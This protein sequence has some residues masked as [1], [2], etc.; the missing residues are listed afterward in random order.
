M[1]VDVYGL[2]DCTYCKLIRHALKKADLSWQEHSID[3]QEFHKLYPDQE[4]H[5]VTIDDVYIGGAPA[6]VKYLTEKK[7]I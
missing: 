7:L 2:D 3:V 5:A 4:Y 6:I 1:K